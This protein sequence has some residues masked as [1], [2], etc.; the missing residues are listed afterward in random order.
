MYTSPAS[1][2]YNATAISS[3][4][5]TVAC[6]GVKP[7]SSTGSTSADQVVIVIAIDTATTD[8]TMYR[9][10]RDKS[11]QLAPCD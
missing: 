2:H 7:S 3:V 1:I 9:E 5:R 10:T 11:W 8:T 4:S 6:V